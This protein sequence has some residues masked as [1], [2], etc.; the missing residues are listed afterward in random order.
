MKQIILLIVVLSTYFG[1]TAQ[2]LY[3]TSKNSNVTIDGGYIKLIM[4]ETEGGWARGF[5][6]YSGTNKLSGIGL[7]GV[8]STPS[9]LY[10]AHGE[11][12]WSSGLG[13]Y[14]KTNGF[15]GIGTISPSLPIDVKGNGSISKVEGINVIGISS[16]RG[17]NGSGINIGTFENKDPII[18]TTYTGTDMVF[19]TR[20]GSKNYE[21]MRI[22]DDGKIGI[23]TNSPTS[24]LEVKNGSIFIHGTS[25]GQG[26][27]I[28]QKDNGGNQFEW[29]P[30]D[31]GLFL[32]NRTA[33][34]FEMSVLNNG[35]VGIGT[36]N[37]IAKF[38]VNHSSNTSWAG[39]IY[40]SGGSGK[41]LLIKAGSAG[42]ST[43][44]I[45]QLEDVNGNKRFVVVST[46]DAMLNG[47]LKTKEVMV[48]VDVWSDFVFCPQHD[49]IPL[50]KLEQYIDEHKHLPDVPSEKEVKE[51]GL[52][53]GENN[54][55]LLQK[56]EE[57]TLY[58][59]EQNKQLKSQSEKIL[60]LEKRIKLLEKN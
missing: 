38:D 56:I 4:P 1:T 39:K 46:G 21:R 35:N 43:N 60:N 16:F 13:I 50:D 6:N 27:L 52:N 51:K 44:P 54:A 19:G 41:G 57:L 17:L 58:I 10:L 18:R 47:R 15:I 40:N 22:T 7:F 45:L 30:Q 48:K 31:A 49:L 32:Y 24:K 25:T 37:P 2:N 5:F 59:I 34:S 20:L 12:P 26:R 29:Y 3:P 53:L 33:K 11:S 9:H 36:N 14:I 55:L 28:L 23:G 42:N 8:G